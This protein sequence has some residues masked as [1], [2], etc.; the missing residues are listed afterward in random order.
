MKANEL[1]IGSIV[2]VD[3]EYHPRL[4]GVA[5]RVTGSYEDAFKGENEY[6]VMLQDVKNRNTYAPLIRFI[7]PIELTE[8]ILLNCGFRKSRLAGYDSH[9]TYSIFM[10]A[11]VI[12]ITAIYNADFSIM[13]H[14]VARKIKYLHELQNKLFA[15][16]NKELEI[17]L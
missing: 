13:L 12:N 11:E 16:T 2:M 10:G 8:N 1:R 7:K 14:S 15:I 17:A 3:T 9:F 4:K 6:A 5:L